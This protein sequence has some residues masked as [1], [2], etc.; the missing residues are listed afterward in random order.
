MILYLLKSTACLTLFFLFYKGLL[1]SAQMHR[2]KRFYLL[3]SLVV[4]FIIPK[5]TFVQ[6]VEVSRIAP[7][8]K[9]PLSIEP[10]SSIPVPEETITDW[11]SLNVPLIFWFLYGLGVLLFSIRFSKNLIDI[12]RRIRRNQKIKEISHIKV[13]VREKLPPHTFLKYIFIEKEKLLSNELAPEILQH[14]M[15][16]AKQRHTLDILFIE[17]L[18]IAL[19]FNPLVYL[20]K[21]S[22][23]LNHEFLADEAVLNNSDVPKNYQNTLLSYLSVKNQSKYP[24]LA[25]AS[26]LHYSSI[27]KRFI[28]MKKHTSHQGKLIR[29]LLIIPLVSLFLWS[30]SETKQIPRFSSTS[31]AIP[32]EIQQEGIFI[33][34]KKNEIA[35][36][37]KRVALKDFAKTLDSMTEDWQEVDYRANRPNIHIWNT[38]EANLDKMDKEF[39]KTR[40]SK[41]NGGMSLIPSSPPAPPTPPSP[42]ELEKKD[43]ASS[44]TENIVPPFGPDSPPAPPKPTTPLEHIMEMAK[45]GADFYYENEKISSERAID[46]LKNNKNL[47][48]QTKGNNTARPQVKISKNPITVPK[49]SNTEGASVFGIETGTK[50]VNGEKLFYSKSQKVTHYFNESGESVDEKGQPLTQKTENEPIFFYNGKRIGSTKASELLSNNTSI[51]VTQEKDENGSPKIILTDLMSS[52]SSNPNHTGIGDPFIDISD[53]VAQNASFYFNDN[54]ISTERAYELSQSNRITRVQVKKK[55]NRTQKVFFWGSH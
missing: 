14:E 2:F 49:P 30:F 25:M 29:I 53:A 7:V 38:S 9:T 10:V 15:T 33:E 55:A 21:H 43:G 32:K 3:G 11:D 27:K 20:F 39:K 51:Q 13:L 50:D 54:P 19:W 41:V 8:Q 42:E 17:L 37:G 48:I 22:I 28:V 5:L 52:Y 18:Q 26:T 23:K 46:I 31:S 16:H 1:E 44:K 36:N 12:I 24:S 6:Y 34:I 4:S 47:N 45:K 40:L 35:V